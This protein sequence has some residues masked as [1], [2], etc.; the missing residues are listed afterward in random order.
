MREPGIT[1]SKPGTRL[2]RKKVD[3][4]FN[5]E[6]GLVAFWDKDSFMMTTAFNGE[7]Y[8]R[9]YKRKFTERGMIQKARIFARDVHK[10]RAK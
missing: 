2:S 9:A 4:H 7:Q 8:S 1:L 6:I 5:T 3:G 10:L